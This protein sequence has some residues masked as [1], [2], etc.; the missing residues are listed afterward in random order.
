MSGA[1]LILLSEKALGKAGSFF[2]P[3]AAFQTTDIL[4]DN[5]ARKPMFGEN[6]PLRP[7][8]RP[9]AAKTGTTTKFRDN[10]TAG[11]TRY[12][13]TGVW[14]GE[15]AMVDPMHNTTG[16]TGAAPIWH[17]FMEA[18][19]AD[20]ALRR[21]LGA[22]EDPAAWAVHPAGGCGAAGRVSARS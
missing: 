6:S 8:S 21:T 5:E 16:L 12:L 15:T 19:L 14:S 1:L 11:Y 13:V 20:P 17:A 4:S 9:A 7:L 10:W 2:S 3:A 18:V 22:P